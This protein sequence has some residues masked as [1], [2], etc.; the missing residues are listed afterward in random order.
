MSL[1]ACLAWIAE[2]LAGQAGDPQERVKIDFTRIH[3]VGNTEFLQGERGM[4]L[5]IQG[6][7]VADRNLADLA[8]MT[9]ASQTDR[10]NNHAFRLRQV[11]D[12]PDIQ[13]RCRQ[14][15]DDAELDCAFVSP[16]RKWSDIRLVAMDMDSTLVAIETIDEIADMQGIRQQVTDITASA[17]RGEIDFAESLRRRA[18]L[19]QGLD[20]QALHTVYSE[21]MKLNPGAEILLQHCKQSGIRTMLISGGF[22][23]FTDRLG[24]KL[25]LDYTAANTLEIV[26]GRLTGKVPG[27][28]IG[29]EG[30]ADALQ[31]VMEEL[32]LLPAQVM[33]I[34]D[35]ANDLAMMAVAGT[36][37]GYHAKPVVQEKATWSL[38]HTG[39][40]GIIALL[41]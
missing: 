3:R 2:Y 27:T 19:L 17:M 14:Y 30:K 4:N 6:E 16:H 40:D 29:A 15:C 13:Q 24:K 37:I 26:D 20:E 18:A 33:A 8:I 11:G 28:I 10:I 36:S 21:R 41:E 25:G 12:G 34:G 35:G 9:G 7:S 1:A 22:T 5:I 31:R 38:N 32:G 39:L 23:F